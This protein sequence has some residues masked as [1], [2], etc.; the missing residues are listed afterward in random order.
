VLRPWS[1]RDLGIDLVVTTRQGGVSLGPYE[2]LNL[3]DHVGDEPDAVVENRRRLAVELGVEPTSLAI[4]R[5]V[6]GTAVAVLGAGE[7]PGEADVLATTD[8]GVALC[9]L[10][11][12][13]LPLALV[14]PMAGVVVL[15][16]AGWRGTAA[17]VAG[18]A[19]EAAVELGAI[20]S[21]CHALLGPCISR[22]RY[23]VG[24]EVAA[25]FRAAGCSAAVAPDGTGRYLAD[26]RGANVHQLLAAGLTE[27]RI[28]T[29]VA[30]TDGGSAFFSDRAE[31]P[32]GRFAM[33]ARPRRSRS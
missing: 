19:V 1:E 26:L 32:C 5:Q 30:T 13:C 10:V 21:R 22:D 11:A 16:H 3:G 20:A 9:V 18:V 28:D 33:A 7:S 4:A 8:A 25:A 24:D 29:M 31:R 14:D 12:D 15:A 6:H 17:R 23:Q 27:D 2:S